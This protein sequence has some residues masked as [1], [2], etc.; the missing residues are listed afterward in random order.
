ME[1]IE[2][3]LMMMAIP[4]KYRQEVEETLRTTP[5]EFLML[6]L[7]RYVQVPGEPDYDPSI[8]AWTDKYFDGAKI[9]EYHQEWLDKLG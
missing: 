5:P 3:L 9:M 2:L 6:M 4:E 8:K 1:P 7:A